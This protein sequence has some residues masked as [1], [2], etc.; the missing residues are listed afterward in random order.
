MT[1]SPLCEKH[2][3]QIIPNA[4]GQPMKLHTQ[5]GNVTEFLFHISDDQLITTSTGIYIYIYTYIYIHIYIHFFLIFLLTCLLG[6]IVRR[7][8]VLIAYGSERVN[9]KCYYL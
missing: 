5:R 3:F 8:Y 9:A 4:N 1:Y 2:N 6:N 7:E